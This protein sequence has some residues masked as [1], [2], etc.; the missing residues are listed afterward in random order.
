ML[1]NIDEV[2]G[3]YADWPGIHG[4]V[5]DPE[6][7][8][9]EGGSAIDTNV[10]EELGLP[11][12]CRDFCT[13]YALKGVQIG[14]VIFFQRNRASSTDALIYMNRAEAT[15]PGLEGYV[16]IGFAEG[17]PILFRRNPSGLCDDTVYVADI[18]SG[19]DIRIR[20][21][22]RSFEEFVVLAANVHAEALE[23]NPVQVAEFVNRLKSTF[24]DLPDAMFGFWR[25]WYSCSS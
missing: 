22:A 11:K 19:P 1:K 21:A 12:A 16:V 13:M 6:F 15:L 3:F 24:P 23:E 20:E 4:I 5:G 17:D 9:S 18:S 7:C 8:R 10:A 2:L 14:F 25:F